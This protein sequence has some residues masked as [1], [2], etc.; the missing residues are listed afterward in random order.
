MAMKA[1]RPVMIRIF[2]QESELELWLQSERGYE[3]FETYPICFWSGKLGP[4]V[5]E[6]DRQAPEGF[7]RVDVSQLRLTGRNARSF[8]IDFP[9]TL[10]RALGRTG[11]SIMV[12]GRCTSTGCFAMTNPVMEEIYVW[13]ERALRAGQAHIEVHAFPFRLTEANLARHMTSTWYPY[14]LNLKEAY[15]LFEHTR[16]PPKVSACGP[17]YVIEAGYGDSRLPAEPGLVPLANTCEPEEA[18]A[19][20]SPIPVAEAGQTQAKPPAASRAN[21]RNAR[22]AY[23]AARRARV[24]AYAKRARAV[25]AAGKTRQQ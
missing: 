11:S 6:G 19:W 17:K 1:G 22:Q 8:Y 14:W 23:A 15:D 20:G 10:D 4:K 13:V 7:Y 9:N 12:H 25:A 5:R 3:L 2:K 16:V 21:G 18:W 24:A